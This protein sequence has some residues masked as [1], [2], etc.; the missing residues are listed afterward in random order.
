MTRRLML[1]LTCAFALTALTAQGPA[2]AKEGDKKDKGAQKD[3][4]KDKNGKDTA[5]GK[6]SAAVGAEFQAKD[7]QALVNR[8]KAKGTLRLSLGDGTND[9]AAEQAKPVLDDWF[10]DK[11]DIRV[12][13]T[14]AKELLGTLKLK[15][16][17]DGSDKDTEK[18]LL[19]TLEK[20]E[21]G[22]GFTL[23]KI[24]IV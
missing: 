10:K 17:K 21:K 19:V 2:F 16:R 23:A 12:E 7:S 24:E 18:V 11:K 15:Y 4:K 8:I 13:L 5:E 3:D 22:E 14:S 1:L 6:A 20:K 9:Y